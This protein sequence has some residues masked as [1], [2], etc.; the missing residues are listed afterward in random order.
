MRMRI[1][2]SYPKQG[3]D[4]EN[5]RHFFVIASGSLLTDWAIA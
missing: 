3:L 1:A 2:A 5:S 4:C